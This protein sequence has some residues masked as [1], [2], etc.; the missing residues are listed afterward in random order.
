MKIVSLCFFIFFAS[1][2]YCC[3]ADF[4]VHKIIYIHE[5]PDDRVNFS[6]VEQIKLSDKR[7]YIYAFWEFFKLGKY[8]YKCEIYDASNRPLYQI[9]DTINV[10]NRIW[11]TWTWYDIRKNIDAHGTWTFKILINNKVVKKCSL[12]VIK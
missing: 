6:P 5:L 3:A 8:K 4:I 2:N 7:V 1:V 9:E 12:K 11:E 10:T